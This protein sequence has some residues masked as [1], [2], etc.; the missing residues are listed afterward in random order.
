MTHL[1]YVSLACSITALLL[2]GYYA[3]CRSSSLPGYIINR[4]LMPGVYSGGGG[5]W[6]VEWGCAVGGGEGCYV[7]SEATI[8]SCV[9]YLRLCGICDNDLTDNTNNLSQIWI[10]FADIQCRGPEIL[11]QRLNNSLSIT[12]ICFSNIFQMRGKNY[13]DL[14]VNPTIIT[15]KIYMR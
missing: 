4:W 11:S 9:E 7:H 10:N 8:Y 5:V 15:I 14:H 3:E 13:I 12:C 2:T 1:F 6:S